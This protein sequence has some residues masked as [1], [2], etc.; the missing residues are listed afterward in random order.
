VTYNPWR[1]LVYAQVTVR[2]RDSPQIYP[3]DFSQNLRR[4]HTLSAI[5]GLF[6]ILDADFWVWGCQ[7]GCW[8]GEWASHLHIRLSHE[9]GKHIAW[10]ESICEAHGAEVQFQDR[11]KGAEMRID[12]SGTWR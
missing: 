11:A 12:D 3:F 6:S 7:P 8:N 2:K 10:W 1:V 5:F 9:L 4:V